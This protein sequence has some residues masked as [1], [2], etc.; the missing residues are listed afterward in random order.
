[1]NLRLM[2]ANDDL[3]PIDLQVVTRPYAIYPEPDGCPKEFH[4]GFGVRI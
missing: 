3:H 2:A 4:T 1:M